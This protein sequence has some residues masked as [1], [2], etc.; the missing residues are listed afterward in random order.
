MGEP[1]R[2][3]RK[4]RAD[5]NSV[6]P[7]PGPPLLPARDSVSSSRSNSEASRAADGE[8]SVPFHTTVENLNQY[9][10]TRCICRWSLENYERILIVTAAKLTED[11]DAGDILL[12]C[13]SVQLLCEEI[14]RQSSV[15]NGNNPQCRSLKRCRALL[16]HVN[17]SSDPTRPLQYFLR[18]PNQYVSYAAAR[19]LSA[20][21]K[22][23]DEGACRVFLDC[24]L[25]NI[26]CI[27]VFYLNDMFFNR[28]G[29][30][31]CTFSDYPAGNF[32]KYFKHIRN[33]R[34][35]T[36]YSVQPV[37]YTKELYRNARRRTASD[38]RSHRR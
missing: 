35:S 6:N 30:I 11:G 13:S 36:S 9:L 19:A 25:N 23:A 3:R 33:P 31:W 20:W 22:A 37:G 12:F 26:V 18:S 10:I 28:T 8:N 32:V 34:S 29:Y 5:Q 15:E 24:L 27:E 16:F 2:K 17:S 38:R 4:H 21:L 7:G 1:D 14:A